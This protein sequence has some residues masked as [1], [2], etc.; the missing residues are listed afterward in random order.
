MKNVS[1]DILSAKKKLMKKKLSSVEYLTEVGGNKEITNMIS[2]FKTQWWRLLIALF[3]LVMAFVYMCK[4]CPD[5]MTIEGLDAVLSNI[6]TAGLF[7]AGFII[8][9]FQSV[10][11]YNSDRIELLEKKAEKYDALVKKV[12]ALQ[13]LIE[14]EHKYSD[15]LN[16]RIDSLVYE[17][18]ELKED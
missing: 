9:V 17:V 6:V 8:W 3:S 18:K 13:E 15:H 16:K 1:A 2:Y 12:D 4:P 7:F 10:I 11:E 5:T 14:T